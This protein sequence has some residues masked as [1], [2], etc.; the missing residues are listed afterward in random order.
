MDGK[1]IRPVRIGGREFHL[2]FTLRA[3]LQL[4][5]RFDGF[6][7][8]NLNETVATPEGLL[9]ALYILAEN[10]E[11]LEGRK[12]DVDE[13]WFALN[14]PANVRKFI[15]IQLAVMEA[16]TAG[17]EMEADAD[18]ERG[19]EVDLVLQ[20]IQKKSAKTGSPGEKSQPGG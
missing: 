19:R 15:S 11:L 4:R 1:K 9:A 5:Q 8:G 3:M 14:V 6:D 20:E 10:G 13:D 18:D 17:M 12:L 7:F 2:A 16:L